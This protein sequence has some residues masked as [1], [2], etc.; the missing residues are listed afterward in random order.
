MNNEL[1]KLAKRYNRIN[2]L[3]KRLEDAKDELKVQ[4]MA[5]DGES[6]ALYAVKVSEY[7]QDRL[8]SLSAI[9]DKSQSLWNALHEAGCVKQITATRLN[10]KAVK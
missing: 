9:K 6:G 8:E 1:D 3:M 10:L 4:L 5:L 7:T 2:A